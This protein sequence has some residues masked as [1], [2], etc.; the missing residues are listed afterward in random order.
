MIRSIALASVTA[1]L[2]GVGCAAPVVYT[3]ADFNR[4]KPRTVLVLPPENTTSNTEVMEKCYPIIFS[5]LA[6]RGY[7]AVSPE[8]ALQLFRANKL[9]DPGRL[10]RLP[11]KTFHQVFAVDAVLRTRVTDWSSKYVVLTSVVSVGFDMEL[12]DTRTGKVLWRRKQTLAKSPN[13]SASGGDFVGQLVASLVIAAA[14]AATTPYEPIA[15]EN[16]ELMLNTLPKG[17][18]NVRP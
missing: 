16:A 14:H 3:T 15:A 13:T 1:V 2:L 5:K 7:Y 6:Q 18:I 12:V 17:D 4:Y 11:T 9:N 8:L 10:N